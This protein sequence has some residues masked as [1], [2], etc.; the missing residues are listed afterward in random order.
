MHIWPQVYT[1][2]LIF[3]VMQ[4]VHSSWNKVYHNPNHKQLNCRASNIAQV[5][6]FDFPAQGAESERLEQRFGIK[7]DCQSLHE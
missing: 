5:P 4:I 3:S 1:T 6:K 2:L 7:T